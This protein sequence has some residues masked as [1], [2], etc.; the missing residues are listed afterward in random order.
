MRGLIEAV[1]T[2]PEALAATGANQVFGKL[3]EPVLRYLNLL[4][5][6]GGQSEADII[7][8]NGY[9]PQALGRQH[10]LSAHSV[11]NFFLPDHAPTGAIAAAGLVAPE[12]QIVNANSVVHMLNI[13]DLL[14][15]S[16][17]AIQSPPPFAPATLALDELT[18]LADDIDALL[19]RL[20]LLLAQ[21]SLGDESRDVIKHQLEQLPDNALRARMGIYMVMMSADYAVET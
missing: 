3:R 2:D 14:L 20:Q 17:T 11:F 16:E 18:T 13:Q 1:L 10:P 15:F 12:F 8:E 6:I 21:G 9:I 4:R 5:T 19:D 7:A